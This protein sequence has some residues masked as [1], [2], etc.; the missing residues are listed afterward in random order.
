MGVADDLPKSLKEKLP[1]V[2]FPKIIPI[3]NIR[4]YKIGLC[5]LDDKFSFMLYD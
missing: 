4:A 5:Q 3:T 1:F 2:K